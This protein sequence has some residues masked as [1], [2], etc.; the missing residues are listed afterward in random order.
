MRTPEEVLIKT[1][2]SDN[3][4]AIELSAL[5]LKTS[6]LLASFV[7]IL[8]TLAAVVLP[9]DIIIFAPPSANFNLKQSAIILIN[10]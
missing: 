6:D 7:F 8:T 4:F 1:R 5:S 3:S 9:F 2:T 10:I